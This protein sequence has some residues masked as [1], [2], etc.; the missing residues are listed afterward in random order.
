MTTEKRHSTERTEPTDT[1][2]R[3]ETTLTIDAPK[4]SRPDEAITIRITGG[5][6][7]E[8]IDFDA[9][10]RD[11][12]G[13]KWRSHATVTADAE[14]VVDLTKTA[15]EAGTY[16]G[17]R[18]MGWLWSMHPADE[19]QL[20]LP[21]M[22]VEPTTIRLRA[23]T[24]TMH[25]ER[26]ITRAFDETAV[27]RTDVETD[28]IVGT[29][30]EPADPGPHPGV[31][32]L[33]GSGGHLP[34]QRAALLASH[35]FAAFALRYSG[36]H[37][38]LPDEVERVS[39]EYFD[40]SAGW[41]RSRSTVKAGPLGIVGHSRGGEVG[42][43]LGTRYD[44]VGPIVS[45]AGSGVLWDTPNGAPAWLDEDGEA[46]PSVSGDGKPTLLEGQ[47]EAADE[48]TREAAT[49]PVEELEGPVLFISGGKDPIWPARRL[50]E[51]GMERLECA[52]FEYPSEHLTYDDA[53]H[54]ITP[55]YLPKV[56]PIFGGTAEGMAYADMDSW[57]TV[58]EYLSRGLDSDSSH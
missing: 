41:F 55:P 7:H 31:L 11:C 26:R 51:I 15:P 37:E 29:L 21:L 12:E 13:G 30:V 40:R 33:H 14:G 8:T 47:L 57:P 9:T 34:V 49:I 16:Q 24:D 46:L 4:T 6:P 56:S 52:A 10:I 19:A 44:W 36:E 32:V 58:L 38:R 45:Y 42:L 18:P 25:S 17:V 53:G 3:T 23:S 20:V 1:T 5:K 27:T 48:D 43:L 2:N 50:A 35:G 28:G 39:L 54:F 22:D